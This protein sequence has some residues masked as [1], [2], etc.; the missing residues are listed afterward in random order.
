MP[1]VEI[2]LD[3]S[4]LAHIDQAA[5]EAALMSAGELRQAV[6]SAQVMPFDTGTLQGS[7]GA[8]DQFRE[9][10]ELHTTLCLGDTPY[11]RRLYF[12]PEYNFQTGNNPNARGLWAEHWLEGG[13]QENFAPDT[14]RQIMEEN[15]K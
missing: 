11:A 3:M 6:S 13:D 4:G 5:M 9:G 2:K 10:S 12:H 1:E 14:F 7:I 15:L 8:V